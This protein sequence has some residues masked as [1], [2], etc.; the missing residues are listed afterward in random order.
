[1]CGLEKQP[2]QVNKFLCSPA[3]DGEGWEGAVQN[4]ELQAAQCGCNFG[5]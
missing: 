3:Q 2:W 4:L 5:V 1:M